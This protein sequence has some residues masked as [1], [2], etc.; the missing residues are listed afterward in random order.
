MK[1][2]WKFS[3]HSSILA[4]TLLL[5]CAYFV[6]PPSPEHFG[7]NNSVRFYLTKSLARDGSVEIGKYY[8]GGIDAAEHEG[9]FYSGKAPA[10]SFLAV[11]VYWAAWKIAGD[12]VPDWIYLYLVRLAVISLPGVILALLIHRFLLRF[13]VSYRRALLLVTGYALGTMAFPYSTQFVGHQLAA[14]F[15]FSSLLVLLKWRREGSFPLLLWGGLLGGMAVAAD[16]PAALILALIVLFTVFSFR[17]PHHMILF[18][19][20]CL[21]GILLILW[22][23]WACFG[24]PLSFPYAHEAMPIAREVQSQGLFGV[25][26]PRLVPLAKL[27][28]SPWR[29]IFF[30]S[31]FLLLAVPGFLVLYRMSRD[32]TRLT[33]RTGLSPKKLFWLS[34]CAIA[35]YLLFN[36]SYGAWSGGSGYG[37]RFL[38]P[39]I[40]FFFIPLAALMTRRGIGLLTGILL[41]Y[42]IAFHFIGTAAGP[43]AHEYLRNPVREF[44]LPSFLRGNIR[45][46]IAMLAGLPRAASIFPLIT[47][48]GAGLAWLFKRAG[49][50]DER[51]K[52]IPCTPTERLLVRSCAAA[53]ILL[54]G[55]FLFHRTAE[56]GYREAV[57]GHSYDVAGDPEQAISLFEASLAMEPKN[58]L[59]FND[60]TRLLVESGRYR[61][62][63]EMNMKEVARNPADY[64]LKSRCETL[65][66]IMAITK[67][68][69]SRPDDQMLREERARLL[70][71][72]GFGR[73]KAGE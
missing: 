1:H 8:Q 56:T 24:G 7:T 26:L 27:L 15:L 63:F 57:L 64:A 46:N 62:A 10:A 49:K 55:L 70:G 41:C 51:Y 50:R 11:P 22:Y 37:P 32:D 12:A 29:G 25:Q 4:L 31:P 34:L 14:V 72:L 71:K 43:L 48:A 39:V 2:K 45:P 30:V 5:A 40:P 73:T 53:A 47:L 28:F 18:G 59:V 36:S 17:R 69:E 65:A 61:E 16:Y 19:M 44:L 68:L 6:P 13:G 67:K 3:A 33:Q 52:T 21:P 35:A 58:P 23:N 60:L 42:S 54:L 66:T 9:R 38:V 20:G